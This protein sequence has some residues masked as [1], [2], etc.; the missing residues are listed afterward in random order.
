MIHN[1]MDE[2]QKHHE[3]WKKLHV[4]EYILY[5]SIHMKFNNR[6]N[7]SM[8]LESEVVVAYER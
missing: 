5:D 6:Q 3:E 4:K 7:K 2:P 1:N 8:V